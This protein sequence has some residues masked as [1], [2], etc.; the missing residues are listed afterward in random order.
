[1][2]AERREREGSER[3]RKGE[4]GEGGYRGG[5]TAQQPRDSV[6]WQGL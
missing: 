4:G 3:R 6:R 1:M 5:C 2:Q